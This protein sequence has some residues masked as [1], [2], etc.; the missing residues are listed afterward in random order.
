MEVL[1]NVMVGPVGPDTYPMVIFPVPEHIIGIN[2]LMRAIVVERLTVCNETGNQK[3]YCI[4]AG[5]VGIS[6][7]IKDLTQ[8]GMLIAITPAFNIPVWPLQ[9]LDDLKER[10]MLSV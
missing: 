8:A 6:T 10:L 1:A 3:Q 4:P 5:I 7:T 2:M 9:K